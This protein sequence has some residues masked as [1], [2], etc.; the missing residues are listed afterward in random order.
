MNMNRVLALFVG[1]AV[2]SLGGSLVPQAVALLVLLFG[3]GMWPVWV[4]LGS[5]AG[6]LA[7]QFFITGVGRLIVAGSAL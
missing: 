7:L 2:W 6:G 3:S 4:T 5:L 1:M